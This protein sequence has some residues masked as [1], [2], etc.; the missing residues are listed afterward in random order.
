MST[1]EFVYLALFAYS[2]YSAFVLILTITAVFEE[3]YYFSPYVI[4]LNSDLNM[5]G[6]ILTSIVCILIN[7]MYAILYTIKYILIQIYRFIY[8]ICHIGYL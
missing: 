4:Y 7:P 1:I 3:E 2:A 8:W 5:F 6:S